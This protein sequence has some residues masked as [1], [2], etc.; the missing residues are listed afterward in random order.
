MYSFLMQGFL[1]GLAYVAPIGMQNA[2][3]INS[4]AKLPKSKALQIA[5]ITI[6]FDISLALACFFGMGLLLDRFELLKT[7]MLAVGSIAIC[8]IGTTLFLSKSTGIMPSE[9]KDSMVATALMCF[10]VTWLNPQAIIDGTLLVSTFK[11]SLTPIQGYY[12]IAG[13]S[14]A[15]IFWFASL[16]LIVSRFKHLMTAKVLTVVN[17]ICGIVIIYFGVK[18]AMQLFM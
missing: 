1:V 12:F 6:F 2:Y 11:A 9:L 8:Y 15:S 10:T 3:V 5:G 17:K 13:V 7:I 16:A 14:S 18:I 4:A